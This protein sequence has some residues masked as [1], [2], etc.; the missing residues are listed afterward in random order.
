MKML[1]EVVARGLPVETWLE[2]DVEKA[3]EVTMNRPGVRT[4][5]QR[6]V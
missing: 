3:H 2:M 1:G 6:D 4:S 5:L